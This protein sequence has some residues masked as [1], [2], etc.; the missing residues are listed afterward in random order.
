MTETPL[1]FQNGPFRLFGVL[2]EGIL[3]RPGIGK[4]SAQLA[5][6]FCHPFAEEKLISHRIM[7]NLARRLASEE[8][9]CLRFDYMGHGD[10]DG[11]FEDSTVETRLSDIRSAVQFLKSRVPQEEVGLVGVRFGSTLAA[12]AAERM[13]GI[14]RFVAVSPI[15]NGKT[16]ME[17]CL[18][19]NLTTQMALYKK[20]V[21]D[22]EALVRELMAGGMVNI[23]GYLITKAL[24]EQMVSI[25]LL[26]SSGPIARKAL[27]VQ[28]S[29]RDNEQ[30]DKGIAALQSKWAELSGNTEL[31]SVR[32]NHFWQ[33]QKIYQT[34]AENLEAKV[35][36]W[37]GLESMKAADEA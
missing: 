33:D 36:K 25:D 20:V 23:D 14:G 18:R 31:V 37:L 17:Q 15:V 7:V 21:K 2:H 32:E 11:K 24:Y 22:R 27:I 34:K 28:I 6:V 9:T 16:Y 19:S 5:L 26:S 13:G 10:S 1:Y 3:Q 35:L 12:M 30:I 4:K 29:R 8:I